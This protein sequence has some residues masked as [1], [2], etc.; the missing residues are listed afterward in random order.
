MSSRNLEENVVKMRFDNSEFDT[1]IDQSNETLDKFKTTITSLPQN[2]YIGISNAI[3][4][5][6]LS[7]IIGI[8]A[9]LAGISLV[10]QGIIGIGAEIQNVAF[11]ALRTINSV[12][13][14][15]INQINEGGKARALNIA[16][17][18]FQIEGLKLDVE[19]FMTAADYA[20]SGTAYGLDAAA[21]VASQL[22]ASGVTELEE[23]K[24]ALRGVSGVAAMANSSYEEIGHL[25]TVIASNGRLMT[26]QIRSFSARGLNIS[27]ELAK[28]LNKTE[29]EINDMVSKGKIDFKTFYT[30][31][32][33][34][35]GEHAKDANKTFTG[36]L[37]NIRA[38]LSRIGEGLWTPILDNAIGVFN[39]LRLSINAFNAALKDVDGQNSFSIFANAVKSIFGDVENM[40]KLVKYAL[41]ETDFMKELGTLFMAISD[42]GK[43]ISDAFAIDYG[44]VMNDIFRGFTNLIK[45]IEIFADDLYAVERDQGGLRKLGGEIQSLLVWISSFSGIFLDIF[46][47]RHNSIYE[48]INSWVKA[49]KSVFTTITDILG[50]NRKSI[51]DLFKGAVNTVFDL[52]DNLKL[53][54]ERIDKITRTFRGAA[55]VLDI[56]KML[57]VN[58]YKFIRPLFDFLPTVVDESLSVTATIGDWLYNLRNAIKEGEVFERLFD[59]ISKICIF[60][61]DLIEKIG[62]NFFEAFF[63]EGTK[64]DTFLTKIK[65]FIKLIG[66]TVSDAFGKLKINELD[67]GPIQ[68]FINNLAHFGVLDDTGKAETILDVLTKFF[69]KIKEGFGKIGTFLSDHVFT[70]F[71]GENETFNK[72][73]EFVKNFGIGIGS[74]IT[75]ISDFLTDTAIPEATAIAIV[76]LI[77]KAMDCIKDIVVAFIGGL[78]E[79]AGIL[80][81]NFNGKDLIVPIIDKIV[82]RFLGS[83][84]TGFFEKITTFFETFSQLGIKGILVSHDTGE[85]KQAQIFNSI[86]NMLKGFAWFFFSIAVSLAIIALIPI[87]KLE[88]GVKI[89]TKFTI[90]IGVI[91]LVL[92][93]LNRILPDFNKSLIAIRPQIGASLI[94]GAATGGMV[95]TQNP[96]Y[97]VG[98]ALAG[99]GIG[100]LAISAGLF[101]IAQVDETKLNNAAN[102]L[103]TFAFV[104]TLILAAFTILN[105][106]VMAAE[107][108]G[109]TYKGVGIAMLAMSAG[110]LLIAAGF[111]AI[112]AVTDENDVGKII[113][114]GAMLAAILIAVGVLVGFMSTITKNFGTSLLTGALILVTLS[115]MAVLIGVLAAAIVALSFVDTDK[116]GTV[117]LCLGVLV[118]V[119]MGFSALLTVAANAAANPAALGAM[120][121][122]AV[123]L[124]AFAVDLLTVAAVVK[125]VA[126]LFEGLAKITEGIKNLLEFFKDLED[127]DVDRIVLNVA[128]VLI[129]VAGAIS[130][131]MDEY[132]KQSMSSIAKLFPKIISFVSKELI[133]FIDNLFGVV[134]PALVSKTIDSVNTALLALEAYLPDAMGILD[135]LLFGSMGLIIYIQ[136]MLD[137]IWDDTISWVNR[138]VEIWVK[139]ILIILLKIVKAINAAFE[140]DWEEFDKEIQDLIDHTI[141]FIKDLLT[142]EKTTKDFTDLV[143][144]ILS[145][146]SDVV[147]EN[148]DAIR[149]AFGDLGKVIGSAILG[150]ISDTMPD[151]AIGNYLSG[152]LDEAA[153]SIDPNLVYSGATSLRGSNY[154]NPYSIDTSGIN[155]GADTSAVES[156]FI[157]TNANSSSTK[158]TDNLNSRSKE[159]EDKSVIELILD[160]D[161]FKLN[162][163]TQSY[164]N[165]RKHSGHKVFV[166]SGG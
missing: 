79:I 53:S 54:D 89:L 12:F 98:V 69:G 86:S 156:M 144:G 88:A 34:A 33:E 159:K 146:I 59:K 72:F 9:T 60:V 29:N 1:N 26:E 115:S 2:I 120:A 71:T 104:F 35:F 148:K 64:D 24:K 44:F 70:I 101:I 126:G 21:K 25:F 107:D 67:L 145:R 110:L 28:S 139:D 10:R 121:L 38:A 76:A 130:M 124:L 125:S 16:N 164:N 50:I 80:A 100:L 103:L 68:E 162:K 43:R 140:G 6:N 51:E 41:T 65:N 97:S 56:I 129:G 15:A 17:A 42:T 7:D 127:A 84:T 141:N 22:G 75:A 4:R 18:K 40:I 91:A 122:I 23:L 109:A 77:W 138:R 165:N 37:S 161:L 153:N 123:I 52:I 137:K 166:S 135:S 73:T 96:L 118:G 106:K 102:L 47:E 49:L 14:S 83:K 20:V 13:N 90:I 113:A 163:E 19:T 150:G 39:E 157:N 31:M 46:G 3:S 152:L 147:R 48:T 134:I 45:V 117:T 11:G 93:V 92:S 136:I 36:A 160:A 142:N 95:N 111:A 143:D 5:I 154:S 32:D 62:T 87:D 66:E 61:K 108:N 105:N 85:D 112:A 114:I 82:D 8:G 81:S 57:V 78:V 27:A 132:Y 119:I 63:G 74:A 149:E 30:A 151:N 55:S 158:S 133:P 94:G 99:I 131:A 58:I 155:M 128:K 116:L